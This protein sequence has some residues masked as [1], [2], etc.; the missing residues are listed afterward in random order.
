MTIIIADDDTNLLS[1]IVPHLKS[2]GYSVICVSNGKE[3]LKKA[4]EI[5]ADLVITDINMPE[6]DGKETFKKFRELIE[7]K[8]VPVI[9]WS[10]IE[11][12]EGQDIASSDPNVKFIKKPFGLSALENLLKEAAPPK[13]M[14]DFDNPGDIPQI[15]E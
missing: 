3:L 5:R 14:D 8:N 9:I 6:M 4:K 1:M 13:I 12:K 7:Y 10:G 2:L 15:K 11:I